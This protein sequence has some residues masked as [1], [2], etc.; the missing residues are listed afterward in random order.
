MVEARFALSG[1]HVELRESTSTRADWG[2]RKKIHVHDAKKRRRLNTGTSQRSLEDAGD[3]GDT[4]DGEDCAT[5]SEIVKVE[6]RR[7]T[8]SLKS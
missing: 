4:G 6:C 8:P 5:E 1:A 3:A 7:R 2:K